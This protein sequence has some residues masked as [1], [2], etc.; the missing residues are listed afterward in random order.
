MSYNYVNI[1]TILK[2]Y[3][4]DGLEGLTEKLREKKLYI[5]DN[6]SHKVFELIKKKQYS[7]AEDFL[8]ETRNKI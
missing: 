3:D 4:D 7:E 6:Y 8:A 5:D 2:I 1:Y